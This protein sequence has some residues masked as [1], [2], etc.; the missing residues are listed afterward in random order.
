M[1]MATLYETFT[2][3]AIQLPEPVSHLDLIF[4]E[5]TQSAIGTTTVGVAAY[6]GDLVVVRCVVEGDRH[7]VVVRT[8]VK[9]VLVGQRNIDRRAGRGPI[10]LRRDPGKAATGGLTPD[11]ANGGG[12]QGDAM[13]LLAPQ[14]SDARLAVADRQRSG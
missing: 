8:H 12:Q 13:L 4:S 7:A 1:E 9:R 2:S 10:A 6:H 11:V 3:S 5:S 14:S